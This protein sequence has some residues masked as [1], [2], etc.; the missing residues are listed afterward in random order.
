LWRPP[1]LTTRVAPRRL[2]A[3]TGRPLDFVLQ[4]AVAADISDTIAKDEEYF[5]NTTPAPI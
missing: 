1:L 3:V 2:V 5:N 4:A